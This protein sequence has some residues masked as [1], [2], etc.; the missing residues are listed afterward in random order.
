MNG[1]GTGTTPYSNTALGATA[2]LVKAGRCSLGGYHLFNTTAAVAYVQFFNAAA[3]ADVTVGTTTPTFVLGLPA[4][5][6]ATRSLYRP[7]RF[8]LG[9]VI[10]STTTA[11]GSTGATTVVQLD[12]GD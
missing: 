6:G 3:A 8:P 2:A 5:G 9:M 4:S 12:V 11:T 10:A 1:R 7:S